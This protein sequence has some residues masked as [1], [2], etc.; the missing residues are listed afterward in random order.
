MIPVE[1]IN[2]GEDVFI[3]GQ[4]IE[5]NINFYPVIF[6]LIFI[7]AYVIYRFKYETNSSVY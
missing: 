4:I 5:S 7:F 2:G 1:I 6:I 3:P